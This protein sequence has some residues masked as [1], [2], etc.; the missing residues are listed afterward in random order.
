MRKAV[1]AAAALALVF[2]GGAASPAGAAPATGP[3]VGKAPAAW[4]DCPPGHFCLFE[5]RDGGRLMYAY[6]EC[7]PMGVVNIGSVGQG[8]K[9]TSFW[10]RSRFLA[11]IYN[12][13]F[14]DWKLMRAVSANTPQ[15]NF[16]A[17]QNDQ[18][19]GFRV[20]C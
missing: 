15:T 12:W 20:F 18:A 9:V 17:N 14:D 19:D 16:P 6:D 11:H 2:S 7:T 8:D 5:D 13:K 3:A 1:F 4:N 10:N